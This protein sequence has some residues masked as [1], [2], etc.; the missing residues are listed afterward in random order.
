MA[1]SER[2]DGSEPGSSRF[3]RR[4]LRLMG[5]RVRIFPF[6]AAHPHPGVFGYFGTRLHFAVFVPVFSL[7][8]PAALSSSASLIS[9]ARFSSS[10]RGSGTIVSL[11]TFYSFLYLVGASAEIAK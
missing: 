4:L 10:N 9:Q 5:G 8:S 7:I 6:V 1:G 3:N 2:V 11:M